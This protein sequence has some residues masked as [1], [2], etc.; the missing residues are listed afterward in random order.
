MKN[1]IQIVKKSFKYEDGK[2]VP[3]DWQNGASEIINVAVGKYR[4]SLLTGEQAVVGF[5]YKNGNYLEYF[6]QKEDVLFEAIQKIKEKKNAAKRAA[7]HNKFMDEW[8]KAK[9]YTPETLHHITPNKLLNEKI[10]NSGISPATLAARTGQTKQSVYS[11]LSDERGITRETAI[12]YAAEFGCDPRDILFPKITTNIWGKVNTLQPTEM[13]ETYVA[14]RIYPTE[15]K[16]VVVPADINTPTI[17][18]VQVDARGSMY[19]NQ[20]IFYYRNNSADLEINNKLCIVGA[21]GENFFDEEFTHY[22]FGFYENERGKNNLINPD[23]YAE[24]ESKYVLKNFKIEFISPVVSMMDPKAI[25]DGTS[26]SKVIPNQEKMMAVEEAEKKIAQLAYEYEKK[27]Q[28][29]DKKFDE[30][31]KEGSK[32]LD[33][34]SKAQ[35]KL[36]VQMAQVTKE[37]EEAAAKVEQELVAANAK[38]ENN[39]TKRLIERAKNNYLSRLMSGDFLKVDANLETKEDKAS[40]EL[41]KKT[42]DEQEVKK[43]A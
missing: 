1:K 5:I 14:C 39:Y 15:D 21:K 22:Y 26:F 28:D 25:Q 24:G 34:Y 7:F 18:A 16:S 11:Q 41:F 8:N 3:K 43:R 6:G 2:W 19:H 29:K 32:V 13:D 35:E 10:Q 4:G 31:R 42:F 38:K 20:I 37:I 17:R 30:Y 27:L 36:R 33:E 23:P 9:P 40:K 12:K